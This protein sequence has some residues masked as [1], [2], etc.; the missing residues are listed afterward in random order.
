[1]SFANSG[2][3][4]KLQIKI[5][6]QPSRLF[7]EEV[8]MFDLTLII[9]ASNTEMVINEIFIEHLILYIMIYVRSYRETQK[10]YRKWSLTSRKLQ[11]S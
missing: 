2:F 9:S 8:K 4:Y 1:M 5:T 10:K 6:V 3:R 11:L 7:S